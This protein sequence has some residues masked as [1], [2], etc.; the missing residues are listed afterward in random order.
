MARLRHRFNHLRYR[1]RA[2]NTNSVNYSLLLRDIDAIVAQLKKFSS[3]NIPVLWRPLHESEGGWFWWGAKGSEP[4]KQLWRLLYQ[5]RTVFHGLNNLIW[6]L[7]SEDPAWYP[8]DDMVDIVGVDGY[9]T[10]MTDPLS[11]RWQALRARLD[12]KIF[13]ALTEFGGVPDVDKMRS[14]E[15][16]WSWFLILRMISLPICRYVFIGCGRIS[17]LGNQL[18]SLRFYRGKLVRV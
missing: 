5:R 9:P 10:D 15:V 2:G 1:R 14:C 7:A 11:A 13:I 6:V 18:T 12:E 17:L 16:Y 3:N 8:G 4:F